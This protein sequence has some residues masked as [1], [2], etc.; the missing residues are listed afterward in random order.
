MLSLGLELAWLCRC[1]NRAGLA[2]LAGERSGIPIIT[3]AGLSRYRRLLITI[4]AV[5]CSEPPMA[6]FTEN[7]AAL[8]GSMQQ[9]LQASGGSPRPLSPYFYRCPP[10]LPSR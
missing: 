2:P 10:C 7:L 1:R 5:R 3:C 6:Q 4:D 9:F 8:T